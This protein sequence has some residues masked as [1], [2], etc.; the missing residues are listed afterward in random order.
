MNKT[1]VHRETDIFFTDSGVQVAQ[2]D[3]GQFHY[4]RVVFSSQLCSL[5]NS[6]EK[7]T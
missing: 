7:L 3:R 1:S 5:H 4:R 6:K 2:H